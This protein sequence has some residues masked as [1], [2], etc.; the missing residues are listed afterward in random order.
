[1]GLK[2]LFK[3]VNTITIVLSD[4]GRAIPNRRARDCT[5]ARSPKVSGFDAPLITI[6][7]KKVNKKI[8][9]DITTCKI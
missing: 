6:D 4:K 2:S 8:C 9:T 7:E 3:R 5:N 1:M